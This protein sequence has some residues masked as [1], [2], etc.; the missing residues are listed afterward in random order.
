MPKIRSHTLPDGRRRYSFRVDTGRGPDGKRIQEYR[1]FD[2]RTDAERELARIQHESG[3]GTYVRPSRETLGEYLDAYLE[4]ACRNV[5]ASTRRNYEDAL[6][7][8]RD[9]LGGRY[10]RSVS[11]G[12]IEGLVTWM[13]SSG[14]RRGGRAG[15]GLSAR[16]VALTLGRLSA[17]LES[18]VDEGKLARNPARNVKPPAHAPRQQETWTVAEVRR[19][20]AEADADRLAAC[21]RLS[22]YGLRRGEVLGLRWQDIHLKA[23]TITVAQARVL[24]GYEVRV[25]RP[26]SS[27]GARTLP[28]DD[29]LVTALKTLKAR[30]AAERLAAGPTYERTGYVAADELGRPVHPEWY[31]D[32]F[33]RVAARA[34]LRRIRLHESRHTACSLM[35]KAGVPVSVISA[36][37]GHY[38]AAFTMATYVHANPDDL[39]AGRDALSAIYRAG[40]P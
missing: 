25:E 26:K 3:Q 34:Q 6:L 27:N 21:W 38:S 40:G 18:A 11:K 28:L 32:E 31:T 12:D 23:A 14:R 22:L 19:F 33:H 9:R 30:Q 7:P 1:T 5:R 24:A 16:S 2:R 17:A 20:L 4:G 13:L 10:L 29:A 15:T 8:V 37:A 39:A 35:E 36:W